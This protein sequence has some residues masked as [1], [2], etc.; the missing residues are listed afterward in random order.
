MEHPKMHIETGENLS[1]RTPKNRNIK[2]PSGRLEVWPEWLV[3]EL[4]EHL[5][6]I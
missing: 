2:T 4:E 6:I 1:P 3:E 5:S